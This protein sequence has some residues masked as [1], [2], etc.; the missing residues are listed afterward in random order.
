MS[1]LY[2]DDFIGQDTL[3]NK[4]TFFGLFYNSNIVSTKYLYM[5]A[6]K[7]T[8]YCYRE[9]FRHCLSLANA[10]ELPATSLAKNCYIQMFANCNSLV[11]APE[12]PA[13]TLAEGCYKNMFGSSVNLSKVVVRAK[14]WNTEWTNEWLNNVAP[15]GQVYRYAE[16]LIPMQNS[17]GIPSN[18]GA[19]DLTD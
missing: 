5:P 15:T 1:L 10:P 11:E 13:S 7:L 16:A 8:T 17:S 4:C 9:M 18:W 6:K 19:I 2:G 3:I 12:L 14:E